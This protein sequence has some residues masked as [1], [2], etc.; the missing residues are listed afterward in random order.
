M[1]EDISEEY[2]S[3]S[4]DRNDHNVKFMDMMPP[5]SPSP[6]SCITDIFSDEYRDEEEAS[7]K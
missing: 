1:E 7:S 6:P 2:D 5:Q 3:N 4:Q